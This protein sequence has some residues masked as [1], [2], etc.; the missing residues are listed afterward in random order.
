MEKII[1]NGMRTT[2]RFSL[3][4]S[5]CKVVFSAPYQCFEVKN[6]GTADIVASIES[7]CAA[8]DS[9]VIIIAPQTSAT[10]AHMRPEVYAVYIT[11]EGNVQVVGKNK[12]EAVFKSGG[13]GGGD[14]TINGVSQTYVDS[15]DSA[16]LKAAKDY[17]NEATEK[18]NAKNAIACDNKP[19]Y[20]DGV[21][22]YIKNGI[23]YS[24]DDTET[25]FYYN[26]GEELKQTIFV[27]GEEFT[28]TSAGKVDFTEFVADSDV[29][30]TYTGNEGDTSKIPDIAALRMLDSKITGNISNSN[31][32]INPDFRI[33]QRGQTEYT[34]V[35]YTADRW[36][37]AYLNKTEI[38][39]NGIKVHNINA[40]TN[41]AWMIQ[42]I[43]LLP[44]GTY[45]FTVK[46]RKSRAD[47]VLRVHTSGT[48]S[49]TEW[50]TVTAKIAPI[51]DR[52]D[53]QLQIATTDSDPSA[54]ADDWVE[55]AWAKLELGSIA[56]SFIPPDPATELVKCQR[57]YQ[58]HTSGDIN[59]VDLRPNMRIVPTITQLSDGN[60]AYDAEIY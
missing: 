2:G 11:G 24:T 26:D 41:N 54:L 14:V 52:S 25:W 34:S 5:E 56:T 4:G 51:A 3:D 33:N 44:A 58:I 43:E 42:R 47:L 13:I 8:S 19:T 27:D 36:Y 60:Y 23:A 10:L 28:I 48:K 49:T 22:S 1:K 59:P 12:V 53:Y 18:I 6:E 7:G 21:I 40:R 9:G 20:A 32:L 16:V 55:I 39:E 29:T 45:T 50:Q 17:A 30:S 31:L 15:R 35:G 38:T 46:L 57:Y 37:M